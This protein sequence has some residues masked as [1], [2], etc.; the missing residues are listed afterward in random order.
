MSHV[1][2]MAAYA[3]IVSVFL[4]VLWKRERKA[5][6]SL[7]LQLLLGMFLGGLVIAW[8]MYFLPTGPPSPIP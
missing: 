6:F 2:L 5:Q 8:I 4:T 1:P 7:F 3:L